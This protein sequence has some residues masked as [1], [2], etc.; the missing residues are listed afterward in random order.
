[1]V[2]FS[3]EQLEF[4]LEHYLQSMEV[5]IQ[6][7][8]SSPEDPY[9]PQM[10][11]LGRDIIDNA[12]GDPSYARQVAEKF[13]DAYNVSLDEAGYHLASPEALEAEKEAERKKWGE[14]G[15]TAEQ[16][17]DILGPPEESLLSDYVLSFKEA[18][19]PLLYHPVSLLAAVAACLTRR[20]W[21]D[22]NQFEIY[23]NLYAVLVGPTGSRKN[24]AINSAMR[25]VRGAYPKLNVLPVDSSPQGLADLLNERYQT[26]GVSDGLL[27][28]PEMKVM[29]G[30][31]RYKD[32]FGVWLTDLY[33]CPDEF[34]R[35]LRKTRIELF[36]VYISLIAG[37]TMAWLQTMPEDIITGGFMPR[38]LIAYAPSKGRNVY[39]PN[40]DK[41]R[42]GVIQKKL[43]AAIMEAHGEVKLSPEADAY[44]EEWYEGD[45]EMEAA[46]APPEADPYYQ[47]ILP[48]TLKVA[49]LMH[50]V[51]GGG[52]KRVPL[53]TV[54]K[55]RRLM[56]LLKEGTLAVMQQLNVSDEAKAVDAV[57]RVVDAHN[58]KVDKDILF[59][60]LQRKFASR[61]IQDAI[62]ALEYSGTLK[63]L[64][65][66]KRGVPVY[67]KVDMDA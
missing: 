13:A 8:G 19:A 4:L 14:R 66:G 30:K 55:A 22:W 51:D 25:V 41:E 52:G 43:R 44:L 28:A 65:L 60:K 59:K 53:R 42:L 26:T 50:A 5:L 38:T 35:G 54:K 48:N 21:M 45:V 40:V 12:N 15:D 34:K 7:G 58:G 62:S 10:A 61:R 67:V 46:A 24:T 17:L 2:G 20:Y 6:R 1:M 63:N 27:L 3:K 16:L 29:F 33:D 39:R 57:C 37:T 64:G 31:D 23:P 36:S 9:L 32:S 18:E 49:M 11:Q 47:R 56:E